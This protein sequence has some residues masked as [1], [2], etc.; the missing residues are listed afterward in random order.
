MHPPRAGRIRGSMISRRGFGGRRRAGRRT[1]RRRLWS[2]AR[3]GRHGA[4]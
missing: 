2:C 4:V 1:D 3:H